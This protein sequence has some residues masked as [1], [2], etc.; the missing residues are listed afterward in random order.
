MVF[1]IQ[2]PPLDLQELERGRRGD[3]VQDGG[4]ARFAEE[5]GFASGDEAVAALA[6]AVL[7]LP[8][9][10]TSTTAPADRVLLDTV[11]VRLI[12]RYRISPVASSG[13][14]LTIAIANPFDID[15]ADAVGRATGLCVTAV[16]ASRSE[17]DRLIRTHLGVRPRRSTACWRRTPQGDVEVL[18]ELEWDG[19]EAAEMAQE[20]SVVRLV[21]EI[22]IEAIESRAS[23]V[24]IES[25]AS[26]I[27]I[28]YRIDGVLHTQP[29][30][31]EIN[32]F[33]AAIISRL[34][35]MSRLNIA[36]NRLP[37][38][39]RIKLQDRRPR[40]RHPRLDHPHDPRR[41]ASCCVCSTR[42]RMEFTL[43][44]ARHG[45]RPLRHVPA[46]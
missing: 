37:Q 5:A 9:G 44:Q 13:D 32:R 38:D 41:R 8:I 1:T 27:R 17:L 34:K 12:H 2:R 10:S 16:V 26:G 42:A 15:S 7:G 22:L 21:N 28:R 35:I 39:G 29:M 45:G 24:H 6:T 4:L 3:P 31:P 46:S 25:Q 20:A 11:P 40:G 33:Q 30:P 14:F 18:E 19:S 43:A 36:E 23:D